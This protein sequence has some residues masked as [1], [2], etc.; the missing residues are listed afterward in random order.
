MKDLKEFLNEA[1]ETNDIVVYLDKKNKM[2]ISVNKMETH[3]ISNGGDVKFSGG[4]LEFASWILDEMRGTLNP[5]DFDFLSKSGYK[6][7]EFIPS[8]N[9]KTLTIGEYDNSMFVTFGNIHDVYVG[10][11]DD[12]EKGDDDFLSFDDFKKNYK[13]HFKGGMKQFIKYILDNGGDLEF[14][15]E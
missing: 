15:N 7:Y 8:K 13:V 12:A 9:N 1:L 11:A 2:H 3:I 6:T 14:K 5:W 4:P 10:Y